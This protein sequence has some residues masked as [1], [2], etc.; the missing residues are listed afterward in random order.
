MAGN[1]NLTDSARN[2][3]DEFYTQMSMIESELRHYTKHFKN[4]IVLCNCDDPYESNFFKYFAIHFNELGLKKLI[5]TC[6]AASPV[7]GKELP[8]YIDRNGQLSFAASGNSR[9][10]E[11]PYMLEIN[12]VPEKGSGQTDQ[13]D[14]AYL[15]GHDGNRMSILRGDGGF[16]SPECVKLL[17]KSDIVVT[18]PPFS[19]F[20]EYLALLM[21]YQ[22]KFLI[23]GNL[24]NI[25]YKEMTPLIT[26]GEI[27]TGYNSGHFWFKVPPTYEEKRTDFKIDENGQ[28]W[29]RMGNICWFT[30]LDIRKRHDDLPLTKHYDPDTYPTYTNFNGIEVSS[31]S[32]IPCDYDGAMGVP[33]TFLT[34]HNPDQFDILGIDKNVTSDGGRFKLVKDGK[35]KTLYARLVIR[36]RSEEHTTSRKDET[37]KTAGAKQN[38]AQIK[39]RRRVTDFGEVY[40]AKKQVRD[41][42]A[43]IPDNEI[44]TSY[45]EPAC[46]NGNFLSE[47][48]K[49]KLALLSDGTDISTF[50]CRMLIAVSSIYGVDI[51]P[52][53][54]KEARER[55]LRIL[56]NEYQA[57]TGNKMPKQF[58]TACARILKYNIVCGD[59]LTMT[60][61][62]DSPLTFSRWTFQADGSVIRREY[63]Y[64]DLMQNGAGRAGCIRK[65]RCKWLEPWNHGSSAAQDNDLSFDVVISNPPYQQDD[66]GHGASAK[67]VYQLFVEQAVRLNPRYLSMIIPARWYAGGKGLD[68]FRR[69]MLHDDRITRLHDFVNASDCFS[70]V[71]IKG[72]VCYFLWERDKHD[73]C[74]VY[75]HKGDEI[76]SAMKRPLLEEGE[77]TFI[78]YNEAITILRKVRALHENTFNTIVSVRKPFGLATDFKEYQKSRD[79]E[80]PIFIYAQHDTGYV[81]KSQILKN[82]DWVGK[83]KLYI[84]EAIGA[85]KTKTDV[86]RPI[87]GKPGTI[88]SETYVVVG[89]FGDEETVR[90]IESYVKTRFFHFMLGLKKISQHTTSKTYALVPM[91][92]FSRDWSDD[93]LYRKYQLSDSEVRFIESMVWPAKKLSEIY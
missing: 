59:T 90:H 11:Q 24:N 83:W 42:L 40:T 13:T 64:E 28:K 21:R 38:T 81:A 60:G 31:T 20:K 10:F 80:H 70:G 39:S 27:W 57:C 46:G 34:K 92:D 45:L 72:G 79:A 61:A 19:K 16:E 12:E 32:D 2:K 14:V 84:P 44:Y 87:V 15:L 89:P 51:Q 55:L 91:Q 50:E 3:Q 7:R 54:A 74:T 93:D 26:N 69:A 77:D 35:T 56:E 18:N 29:R 85:G 63:R 78:R 58:H 47:I 6:Y 75:S 52:D 82:P 5:T 25:T 8:Y 67:P 22:K 68:K 43:M 66:D 76:V 37:V 86:L 73:S 65:Y 71:E 62:D 9:P 48:L 33:I 41:M 88:C 23:I 30:N 1:S 49:R 53:N 36:K 17:R 4:K